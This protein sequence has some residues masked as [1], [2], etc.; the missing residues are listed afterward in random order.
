MHYRLF[1]DVVL[2]PLVEDLRLPTYNRSAPEIFL[3]HQIRCVSEYLMELYWLMKVSGSKA[4][5]RI[6]SGKACN[7]MA[8]RL[9]LS[10]DMREF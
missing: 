2:A 5:V 8:T 4:Q 7:K 10:V 9:L 6:A 3:M 1:V